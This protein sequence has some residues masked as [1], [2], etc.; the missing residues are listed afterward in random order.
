MARVDRTNVWVFESPDHRLS[1]VKPLTTGTV[2]ML[3]LCPPAVAQSTG[4]G[5]HRPHSKHTRKEQI[6]CLKADTL[7]TVLLL[8]FAQF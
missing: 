1:Q 8:H 2:H 6:N 7:C 4:G 3:F 5:E